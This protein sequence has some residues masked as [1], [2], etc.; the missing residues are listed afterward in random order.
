MGVKRELSDREKRTIRLGLIAVILIGATMIGPRWLERLKGLKTSIAKMEGE[1]EV[2]EGA[3]PKFAALQTI[4]PV[5]EMPQA[6]L[7]QKFL[8]REKFAEQLKKAGLKTEPLE[9]DARSKG[10]YNNFKRLTL[11]YTGKAQW[12]QILNLLAGLK[13]N[14]YLA[15]VEEMQIKADPKQQP[16]QRKDLEF[17]LVVSTFVK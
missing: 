13:A 9:A 8:F 17:T 12:K 4:V 14:P 6:E 10:R 5:F 1:L 3:G 16:A 2:A 7:K 11:T 15:G